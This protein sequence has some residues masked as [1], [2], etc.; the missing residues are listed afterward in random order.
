MAF[1]DIRAGERVRVSAARYNAVNRI[2]NAFDG[3]NGIPFG[4]D[5]TNGLTI[6]VYNNSP[7]VLTPGTAISVYGD[8]VSGI[9]PAVLYPGSG[10]CGV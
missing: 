7:G 3:M 9:Y 1:K 4:K 6:P 8:P 5:N 10:F 2:L